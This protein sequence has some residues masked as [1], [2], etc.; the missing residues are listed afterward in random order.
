VEGIRNR[1]RNTK[2]NE[3]A[4]T[5]PFEKVNQKVQS[6]PMS[7]GRTSEQIAKDVEGIVDWLRNPK[8]KEGPETAPL[9]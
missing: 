2:D 7:D 9:K 8:D 1:I 4:E 6:I 5:A 3:E